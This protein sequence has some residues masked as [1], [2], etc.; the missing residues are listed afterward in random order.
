MKSACG[1][2][3]CGPS[4][5]RWLVLRQDSRPGIE[6]FV[7]GVLFGVVARLAVRA[8]LADDRR[9]DPMALVLLPV[10]LGLV[11]APRVLCPC[12]P[13]RSDR[14]NVVLRDL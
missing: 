3:R 12:A 14:S 6:G 11:L 2:A 10:P 1:C 9:L 8:V 5:D 7:I 13:R 4:T